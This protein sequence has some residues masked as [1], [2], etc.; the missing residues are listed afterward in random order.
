MKNLT[1]AFLCLI[2]TFFSC[3]KNDDNANIEVVDPTIDLSQRFLLSEI[4]F[5]GN[6]TLRINYDDQNRPTSVQTIS[7]PNFDVAYEYVYTSTGELHQIIEYMSFYELGCEQSFDPDYNVYEIVSRTETSYTID[8]KSFKANGDF[9]CFENPVY[10][11]YFQEDLIT[12]FDYKDIRF[13]F[14]HDT[15]GNITRSYFYDINE[16]DSQRGDETTFTTWDNNLRPDYL[17]Y[18][19]EV[20]V[21]PSV[22]FPNKYVSKQNPTTF[23]GGYNG[24]SNPRD[25]IYKYDTNGNTIQQIQPNRGTMNKTYIPAN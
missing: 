21:F 17:N 14:E 13:E 10:K 24:S 7:D 1:L 16:G 15:N 19:S 6:S 20:W 9:V 23:I 8:S 4:N 11:L 5:E 2:F 18:F 25:V 22:W 12:G 3:S